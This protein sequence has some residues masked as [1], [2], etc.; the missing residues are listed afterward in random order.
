MYMVS[1]MYIS[2]SRRGLGREDRKLKVVRSRQTVEGVSVAIRD[3]L[4]ARPGDTEMKDLEPRRGRKLWFQSPGRVRS[5][6]RLATPSNLRLVDLGRG[7]L[8]AKL[9][10]GS[11]RCRV[12]PGPGFPRGPEGTRI[13][14]LS[15]SGRALGAKSM[16]SL[17]IERPR[18]DKMRR[19]ELEPLSVVPG[20]GALRVSSLA[21]QPKSLPLSGL[22][23]PPALRTQHSLINWFI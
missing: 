8:R 21:S 22:A 15:V 10:G 9:R 4:R 5:R 20:V 23:S 3:Q 19:G 18:D 12:Y 14:S 7:L 1:S 13:P 17:D 11:G 2:K 6:S 16:A